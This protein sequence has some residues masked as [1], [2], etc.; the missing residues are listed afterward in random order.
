MRQPVFC[1]EHVLGP[2]QADAF[3]AKLPRHFGVARNVGI[4]ANPQ[5]AKLVRHRHE[6]GEIAADGIR[7]D[8]VDL[9][10]E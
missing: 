1:E 3:G 9:T 10:F 4:R 8:R 6:V 5:P 2:A 7:I